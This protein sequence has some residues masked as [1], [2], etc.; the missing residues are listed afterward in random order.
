MMKNNGIKNLLIDFGG[1]LINLERQ[2]CLNNFKRIGI[3]N[4]EHFIDP[5]HQQGAFMQLEK[6]LI[7]PS[8]F[9]NE[10]RKLAKKPITDQQIDNAWNS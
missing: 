5:Y 7:T 8:E 6:G 1:V 9:R 2:T 10:L 3:E 4:I